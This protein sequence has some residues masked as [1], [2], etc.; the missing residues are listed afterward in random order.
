MSIFKIFFRKKFNFCR[1]RSRYKLR[2]QR[3]EDGSTKNVPQTGAEGGCSAG[4]I[5]SV[6]FYLEVS[7]PLFRYSQSTLPDDV[8]TRVQNILIQLAADNSEEDFA[9]TIP[10]D[11][12]VFHWLYI[13]SKHTPAEFFERNRKTMAK[14]FR[15]AL[16]SLLHCFVNGEL[17]RFDR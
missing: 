10:Y 16:I 2:F 15:R 8:V 3:I 5:D 6:S 13:V 11:E 9:N 7:F 1:G 12:T 17:A 4:R 14:V